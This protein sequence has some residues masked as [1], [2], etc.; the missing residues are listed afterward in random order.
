[1][2]LR[3]CDHP[4]VGLQL[5]DA[6]REHDDR[7]L[8]TS[9]ID[10]ALSRTGGA[11]AGCSSPSGFFPYGL[12]ASP[13]GTSDHRS[14]PGKQVHESCSRG[15][16][17]HL[18]LSEDEAAALIKALYDTINDD[19]YPQSPHIGTLRAILARLR[20]EPVGREPLPAPKVMQGNFTP[21]GRY[22]LK[23]FSKA[24]W[25][26]VAYLNDLE[27]VRRTIE[28]V[29]YLRAL[30]TWENEELRL[31]GLSQVHRKQD[32][33]VEQISRNVLTI[34]RRQRG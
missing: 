3:E 25:K 6:A 8:R 31:H 2:K 22:L 14:G 18:N 1:M 4:P 21:T 34:K 30:D 19:R 10:L 23:I 11:G 28:N 26:A 27:E 16:M 29:P 12:S 13:R 20:P 15:E 24:E 7:R 17:P 32:R 9:G 33:P 5:D